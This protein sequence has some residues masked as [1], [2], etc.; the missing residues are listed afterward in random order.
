M[1][2]LQAIYRNVL[3]NTI[4]AWSKV[5]KIVIYIAKTKEMIFIFQRH[6][7]EHH[8][9]RNMIIFL[10]QYHQLNC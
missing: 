3:I 5:N 4:E 2:Q 8:H 6:I 10:K 7:I 1:V 9:C